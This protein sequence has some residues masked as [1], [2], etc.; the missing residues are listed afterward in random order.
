VGHRVLQRPLP[1][2]PEEVAGRHL[3][4]HPLDEA[5]MTQRNRSWFA[6]S[7]ARASSSVF[8][9]I[10]KDARMALCSTGFSFGSGPL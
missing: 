2:L 7:W 3:H 8:F 5:S 1:L 10:S 6:Y 9:S 4:L